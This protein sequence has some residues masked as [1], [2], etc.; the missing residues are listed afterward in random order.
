MFVAPNV[1]VPPFNGVSDACPASPLPI[2][3]LIDAAGVTDRLSSHTTPPAPPP[4]EIFA[5]PPL[6]PPPTSNTFIAVTP[7]G[8]VHVPESVPPSCAVASGF[9]RRT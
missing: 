5:Q 8:T 7:E 6:P 1:D 2:T 3:T 9:L 4:P